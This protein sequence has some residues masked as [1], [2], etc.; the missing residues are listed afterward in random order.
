M[1][2]VVSKNIY[3]KITI[4]TNI[5]INIFKEFRNTNIIILFINIINSLYIDKSLNNYRIKSFY[6]LKFK[7][8]FIN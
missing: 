3:I 4:I 1:F 2:L 5:Y 7:I 6:L 8:N